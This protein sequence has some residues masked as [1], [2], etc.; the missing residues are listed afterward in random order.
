MSDRVSGAV[1]KSKSALMAAVSSPQAFAATLRPLSASPT[2][3]FGIYSSTALVRTFGWWVGCHGIETR[4]LVSL[5]VLLS[6]LA[7]KRRRLPYFYHYSSTT[8]S[9]YEKRECFDIF[10]KL[11]IVWWWCNCHSNEIRG[12]VSTSSVAV[13]MSSLAGIR[14]RLPYFCH[15]ASTISLFPKAS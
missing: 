13:L 11:N 12:L 4:G 6:S 2:I 7:G 9:F 5:Q 15:Y 1:K 14:Q 10:I 3:S 8:R